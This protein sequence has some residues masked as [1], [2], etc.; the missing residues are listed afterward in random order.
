MFSLQMHVP[1]AS[2]LGKALPLVQHM[3]MV[4]VV[5]AIRSIPGYEVCS[6]KSH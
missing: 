6:K 4:A 1:L 5:S 2:A 3:C